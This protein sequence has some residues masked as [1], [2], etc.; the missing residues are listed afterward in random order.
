MVKKN[1]TI[2]DLAGMVKRGF[3]ETAKKRDLD[4]L[5]IDV[6][7]IKKRVESIDERVKNINERVENIEKL[8][9][10]QH[11]FQIQALEKRMK[12][13]EDLFAMNS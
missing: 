4:L 8:L 11:T 1:I 2:D 12:R 7:G 5:K 3:D 9:L 6:D 13:M 10:K